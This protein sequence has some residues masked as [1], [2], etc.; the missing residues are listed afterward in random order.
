MSDPTMVP[1]QGWPGWRGSLSGCSEG[2]VEQEGRAPAWGPIRVR[3][4]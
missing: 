3:E 4:K 1:A 2:A